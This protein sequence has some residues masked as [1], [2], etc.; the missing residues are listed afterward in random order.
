MFDTHKAMGAKII[1][2]GGYEMPVW[3]STVSEEHAAV[4]QAAGLFDATHMGVFEVSGPHALQFLESV[5]TNDVSTLEI[6][7]SHYTYLLFPD[8]SVVDDLMVYRRGA[9]QYM[10]VVNASNND[11]DWAWLNA[12]NNS[13]VLIDE[14][15]PYARVQHRVTLRDLR[16]P[17]HGDTCRVDIPLQGP[18]STEILLSLVDDTVLAQRIKKLPWAGLK[19]P[20]ISFAS[21]YKIM[22]QV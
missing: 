10:L 9:E 5:T 19:N 7:R 4:R 21:G 1:P 17:I 6:G 3:Y 16:D 11:K 20:M 15:R 2:F 8:G 12:V 14:T 18:K 22:A 13:E